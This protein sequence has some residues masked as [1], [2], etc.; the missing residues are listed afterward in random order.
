MDSENLKPEGQTQKAPLSDEA[1]AG[2]AGGLAD[3]GD[4]GPMTYACPECGT[5]N[6]SYKTEYFDQFVRNYFICSKCGEHYVV[7]SGL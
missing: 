5:K 6:D 2:V 3:V 7:D 1:L 4:V